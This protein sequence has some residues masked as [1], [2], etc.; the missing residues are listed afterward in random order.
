MTGLRYKMKILLIEPYMTPSHAIWFQGLATGLNAEVRT[1][2]LPGYHWKWRMHGGAIQIANEIKNLD[3][4]P[5]IVLISEMIDLSLL[6]SLLGPGFSQVPFALYFHE[7]QLTYP[8]SDRDTDTRY[9]RDNHYAFINYTSC[10]VA[11]RIIFNS[12]FHK[13][14]FFSE[15]PVFLKRFPESSSLLQTLTGLTKKA[16]IIAPGFDHH[17]FTT[18]SRTSLANCPVILWNHRWEYDK[19]PDLFFETLANLSDQGLQ[20]KLVVLGKSFGRSPKIFSRAED[21]FAERILQ[22]GYVHEQEEYAQ[23]L[24]NADLAISTSQQDF[25]GISM[26]EAIYA[27]CYPLVPDRLALPALVPDGFHDRCI[28]LDADD[29]ASKITTFI[30]DFDGFKISPSFKEHISQFTFEN[31]IP[32]YE[33]CLAGMLSGQ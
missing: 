30:L 5:D 27:G 31:L 22:F 33:A 29:L 20:F 7:N 14:V 9:S 1:I 15:L 23:W 32:Q 12:A 24:S 25:F 16:T 28:Y 3:W 19:D 21:Q 26:A 2:H 6:K 4:H 8:K 11:D 10:L 13:D 18:T 17:P